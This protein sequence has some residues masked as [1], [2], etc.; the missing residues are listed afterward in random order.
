ME[1]LNYNPIPP[2][3]KEDVFDA[4]LKKRLES[5]IAEVNTDPDYNEHYHATLLDKQTVHVTIRDKYGFLMF[6]PHNYPM[7]GPE[8]IQT[9][10]PKLV[11]QHPFKGVMLTENIYEPC[12][13]LCNYC[14]ELDSIIGKI[15]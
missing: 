12:Y 4:R 9:T 8:F 13:R 3:L 11:N 1:S 10:H 14:V 2:N 6:F 5:Q 15:L 7:N